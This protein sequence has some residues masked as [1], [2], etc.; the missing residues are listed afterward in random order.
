VQVA[1]ADPNRDRFSSFK[2]ALP[3]E[4]MAH[5]LYGG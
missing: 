3:T 2:S 4:R 1:D 5:R